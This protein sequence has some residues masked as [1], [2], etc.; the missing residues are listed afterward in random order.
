MA[1]KFA[2]QRPQMIDPYREG[3]EIRAN[4]NFN[5]VFTQATR[6]I[7]VGSAGNVRLRMVSTYEVGANNRYLPSNSNNVIVIGGIPAGTELRV[8]AD[9]VF[10]TGTTANGLTG[11]F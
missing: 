3:F 1:D 11:L 6:G 10:A 7:W 4:D 2:S 8:C 9:M 5:S